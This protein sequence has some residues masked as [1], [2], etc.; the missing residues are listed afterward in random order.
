MCVLLEYCKSY[1]ARNGLP[2]EF[3]KLC[4]ME[5]EIVGYH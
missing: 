4:P 5:N 2:I 3:L 1:E